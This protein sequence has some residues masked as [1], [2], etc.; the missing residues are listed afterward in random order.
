M[1]KRCA[2]CGE[3]KPLAE[4]HAFSRRPDGHRAECRDCALYRARS[5]YARNRE[6]RHDVGELTL[7]CKHCN[8]AFTYVKTTGRR[9]FYCSERCRMQ[10]GEAAKIARAPEL[11]RRC[12]CGSPDVARVGK[13]VCP[14]CKKDRRDPERERSK[15]RRRT[16]RLYGITAERFE[17]LMAQQNNGCAICNTKNPGAK[18]WAIDHDHACCPGKGSCGNCVRGL[19]CVNC[20]LLLGHASDSIER[21]DRA[22]NY[23]ITHSQWRLPL[24][25]KG[26]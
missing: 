26:A 15:E 24:L 13:P 5:Y 2:K 20:N 8:G 10:A 6:A 19:L 25:Q 1:E 4:F 14:D 7:T 21:L 11:V 12:A 16:L 9:R 18:Q 3:V 23:L 17:E 22:K